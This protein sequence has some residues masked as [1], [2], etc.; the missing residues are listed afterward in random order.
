MAFVTVY[1]RLLASHF[2]AGGEVPL[3][4]Q[5]FFTPRLVPHADGPPGQGATLSRG[6]GV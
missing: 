1:G 3:T 6:A 2:Q 4:G 5:I